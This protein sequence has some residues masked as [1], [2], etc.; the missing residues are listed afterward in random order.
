MSWHEN[1]TEICKFKAKV[2]ITWFNFCLGRVSK[3]FA[4]DEQCEISLNDVVYDFSVEHS[5]I[6]KEDILNIHHLFID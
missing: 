4:K 3:G 5:S 2:N 6:K 1:K